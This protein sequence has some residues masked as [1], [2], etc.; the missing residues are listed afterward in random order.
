VSVAQRLARAG[1]VAVRP[2]SKVCR[3]CHRE[4]PAT[5]EYFYP[6]S[7]GLLR[8]ACKRC[9]H[10]AGGARRR[11]A[12]QVAQ[13]VKAAEGPAKFVPRVVGEGGPSGGFTEHPDDGYRFLCV[14]DS[15]GYLNDWEAASGLLAFIRYYGPVRIFML[16][17]HVDFA[18]ISRF[19]KPPSDIDRIGE[20]VAA[21]QKYLALIRESAPNARIHYLKGNHE[22]RFARFLWKNREAA[23]LLKAKDM[24]LPT[25]L[26]LGK[27]NIE[28]VESGA[29][30]VTPA[31][32]VKHG[33]MVRMRSGYTA[34]GE[35]ERNGVSGISGHSHRLG[36]VYKRS[37]LGVLTWV[38]SGCTCFYDPDYMEG[39]VSDWQQG[40]SFGTIS[41]RGRG[42]SVHT[43][44]IIQGRVKALG[45]DIGA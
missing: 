28:W 45:M 30:E 2:A 16:G 42:F 15:H 43:A 3:K 9:H 8:G 39:Q 44:P 29:I 1:A 11:L 26:E 22:A 19:D 14:P 23:A 41:R 32:V 38:E 13:T 34:T 27:H 6:A 10:Q 17:D 31:L 4:L 5:E 25:Y 37:R 40:L 35:L 18:A 20:D 33:H 36:Q 7:G 24:D 21:C 12:T